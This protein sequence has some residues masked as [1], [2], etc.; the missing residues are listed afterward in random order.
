MKIKDAIQRFLEYCEI[1]KNQSDK[2]LVNYRHYLKRFYDFSGDIDLSTIDLDMVH[3]Y[4][5]HLNRFLDDKKQ[6]LS[7]KTQGY[8]IIALRAFLKF[9][10]K[11]DIETLA[12]EKIELPKTPDR[13]VNFLMSE[14]V[15]RLFDVIDI[16]RRT[17]RRDLA[18][19]HTLYST[20]LRVSELTSLD[21]DQVDLDRREFMVRGKGR[22][23]RIV[24]LTEEAA[25]KI[26]SYLK[27]RDDDYKPLFISHSNRSSKKDNPKDP[28][29]RRLQS[30]DVERIVR[31]A[32]LKAGIIK[33]V[34]PHTLR[35]SFATTLLM[36]GADLRSV[37][38]L[39]GHASVTTTQI[40]TH[41]TNTKLR[42][43]HEAF[44]RG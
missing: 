34:T 38:E 32:A 30:D 13:E 10:I 1:Q 9:L 11:N 12:P 22:K 37:Q 35:H 15:Y 28:N 21:R 19:L 18:M 29:F 4:R 41:V 6:P 26:D 7:L 36:N 24:F 20:G 43:V 17:G 14:E 2:T 44:H 40:Y 27:M 39:L 42:E 5:I 23:L 33:K 3:K 16:T 31:N 8:H 25:K